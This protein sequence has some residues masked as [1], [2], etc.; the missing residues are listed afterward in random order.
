MKNLKF[1]PWGTSH[2]YISQRVV[3]PFGRY[4]EGDLAP[5]TTQI[6]ADSGIIREPTV[7]SFPFDGHLVTSGRP[8]KSTRASRENQREMQTFS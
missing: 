2:T 8:L 6:R 4:D 5:L 1:G 3:Q 7:A